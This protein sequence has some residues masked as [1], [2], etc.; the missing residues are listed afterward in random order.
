LY[1]I[2]INIDSFF[3]PLQLIL[4]AFFATNATSRQTTVHAKARS[5]EVGEELNMF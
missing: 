4:I 3:K 1:Q 2:I 5:R